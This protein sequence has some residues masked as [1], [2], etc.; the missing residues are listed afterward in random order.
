[1]GDTMEV[2]ENN[3][4]VTIINGEEL[5]EIKKENGNEFYKSQNYKKALSYYTEAIDICPENASY[6]GNR[7]ACYMMLRQYQN[8]LDDARKSI[9]L[10]PDF[11]KGH[12]RL[13]KCAIALGDIVSAEQALARSLQ[14]EP[15]NATVAAEMSSLETLR[16]FEKDALKSYSK[17]EYRKVVYCMDKAL[18]IAA[19]CTRNKLTKAECLAFLG[20]FQEAQDIAIDILQVDQQNADAVYVRGLCSYYQDDVERA[21]TLFQHVLRLAPDHV[22]AQD[23]YKKAKLL[24]AKKEE[25]NEAFR[26][27]NFTEAY[28][29]YSDALA[30]DPNNRMTNAKLFFNRATVLS[31]LGRLKE[32]VEDCTV[33]LNIDNNYLKAL[34]RRAKCYMD[35]NEYEEAV[36]DYEKAVKMD[37]SKS[38]DCRKL[39]QEAK[40]AL[41]RS[42][43]KDYYKILGVN[44]GATEDDI[45]K[46]Y[47]KR[48]LVHH[49]DR[50]SDASD[51]EKKEQEK[52]FKEVGEAYGI[53]SDP[54]K[55]ARYD[56]GEDL[57]ES[58]G[59]CS[60]DLDPANVF[61]T[62]FGQGGHGGAFNFYSSGFPSGFSFQFS[63]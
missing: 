63:Q 44:R 18:E 17:R 58:E 22:K 41:K 56:N 29:L 54:K 21:F 62:F 35:L 32:A 28:Q 34:L 11:V 48:A 43:R 24:R 20:R 49:P 60:A 37:K 3:D 39:L 42:K 45:K 47:R 30:T 4:D 23:I 27:G 6:Y 26:K 50:H 5:A 1:M 57:E 51:T 19:A 52:K 14:L 16:H 13:A 61:H 31:K 2:E 15:N 10:D 55:R 59:F 40:I 36:I 12:I 25:G 7:S 46:A 9:S 8:A 38:T 33:A 53:L